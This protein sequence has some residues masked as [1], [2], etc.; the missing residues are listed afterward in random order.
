MDGPVAGSSRI[1]PIPLGPVAGASTALPR[2]ATPVPDA[3]RAHPA[4]RRHS[5]TGREP[6]RI[7]PRRDLRR[8]PRRRRA[9]VRGVGCVRTRAPGPAEQPCQRGSQAGPVDHQSPAGRRRQCG[10]T[11]RERRPSIL[12]QAPGRYQLYARAVSAEHP[13]LGEMK[14]GVARLAW[15][16]AVLSEQ[17]LFGSEPGQRLWL[18]SA[19]RNLATEKIRWAAVL[20]SED[21]Q[22]TR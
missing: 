15:I 6:R 18:E 19:R 3:G 1:G 17:K 22:N 4:S 13:D 14:F 9:G 21:I 7:V 8:R 5:S 12:G 11:L 16:E 10:F 2:H 20:R